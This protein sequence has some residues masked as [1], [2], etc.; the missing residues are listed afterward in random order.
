MFYKIL[1][2]NKYTGEYY[3]VRNGIVTK[4][5]VPPEGDYENWGPWFVHP[6]PQNLGGEVCT[7][8]GYFVMNYPSF[9]YASQMIPDF[10]H[11]FK[12]EVGEVFAYDN[13]KS[14]VKELRLRKIHPDELV[15][16]IRDG[17]IRNLRNADLVGADL[18]NVDLSD[19]NMTGTDL[20]EADLSGAD[21]SGA[22]L[23]GADLSGADLTEADLSRADLT[24]A[25]L[26]GASLSE[27]SL[28]GADLT[29]ANLRGANLTRA[30]LRGA[31]LPDRTKWTTDRDMTEFTDPEEE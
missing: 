7:G 11:I 10:C 14:R 19:A 13:E 4:Y 26:T 6:N 30:N 23:F 27:A 21:L 24:R 9:R 16:M 3:T 2:R 25:D 22:D 29:G 12:A 17:K 18:T 20:T 8:G 1:A 15:K 31:I 28:S 5:P